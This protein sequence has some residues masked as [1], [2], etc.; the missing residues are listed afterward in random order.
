MK[1]PNVANAEVDLRKLTH[2]CLSATHPV[3]K[4]KAAVFRSTLG[5][6]STDAWYLQSQILLAAQKDCAVVENSDEFGDRYSL[7]FSL[8][9]PTG[10]A[11]VRT[12]WIIRAG[13]D[14][15]RLTTCFILPRSNSH[16]FADLD[17]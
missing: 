4:H 11:V 8:A 17:P 10:Q 1:I 7:D 2:Y 5:L 13:E 14:H 3:G 15:P 12:A 6:T 16:E 9:T